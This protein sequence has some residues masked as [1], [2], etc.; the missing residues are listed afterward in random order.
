[1][2]FRFDGGTV[3]LEATDA[4]AVSR[5][6]PGVC[7]DPRVG[8]FRA[9]AS[10]WP[11]IREALGATPAEGMRTPTRVVEGWS[12]IDLRPYQEAALT[13]WELA[14]RRGVVVLPTGA[15]KTMVALAAMARTGLSALCLVPT[16]VLLD[17]WKGAI[18]AV[19]TGPVGRLGDGTRQIERVTVSTFES[20]YRT[21]HGLGNR[22]DLLVV[23]EVHH[24]GS[25]VRD[26]ALEM[27]LAGSRL[28]LTATPPRDPAALGRLQETVGRVV[29]EL[30]VGDLSGA[31]LAPFDLVTIRVDLTPD[32][33]AAYEGWMRQFRPIHREFFRLAPGGSWKAF[34][35]HAARVPGGRR[36]LAALREAR[37]L[38]SY[39]EGK[40]AALA[41]ILRRHRHSR[42]LV[43]TSH[44]QAA[45]S[46]AREHLIMPI[47]CHVGRQERVE[48]LERFR[49]GELRA[50]VSARVLNE[51][52][53]LPDADVAVVIAGSMGE[54]E[55]VQRVGRVLRPA[56][57]KRAMI[58]ELVAQGTTETA[59]S[60][61]RRAALESGETA[62]SHS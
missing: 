57:H 62:H 53:D 43:F 4:D 39:T 22:F 60:R 9:P 38:V 52:V 1:M 54:R 3:L 59:K 28:G 13:A 51:G 5:T 42:V 27:S 16:R 10:A 11:R 6:L 44:N 49:R 24:F 29:Y 7:W 18:E 33:E 34:L 36:A 19:W 31:Y 48:V 30:T 41:D 21:M 26:E 32:E 17:Q 35:R 2:R 58:Y 46:V 56:E 40:R 8:A 25:G 23:D 14:G 45:Y 61:R 50:L 20:A 47:T 37:Q 15:G 12:H 55:H